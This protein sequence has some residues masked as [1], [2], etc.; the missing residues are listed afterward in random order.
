MVVRCLTIILSVI[1]LSPI[2]WAAGRGATGEAAAAAALISRF[3]SEHGLGPVRPDAH[4][5]VL[6]AAQATA[7]ASAGVMAHDVAGD[8]SSRVERASL[9]RVVAA[10]NIGAGFQSLSSALGAWQQSAGHRDNLLMYGV[11][12][13][14]LARAAARPRSNG[15]YWA[16][17]L[18]GPEPS[19]KAGS[20]TA[21]PIVGL[22]AS[23]GLFVGH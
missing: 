17:V 13:I 8:F 4:L 6:A 10:E 15:L 1:V 23:I 5:N 22:P 3:R 19:V 2:C 16:L 9:G 12:R 11:T 18:A 21:A 20:T 14:G 7:M